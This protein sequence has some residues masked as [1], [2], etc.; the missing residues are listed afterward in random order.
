MSTAGSAAIANDFLLLF[1]DTSTAGNAAITNDFVVDFSGSS[2]PN[3]DGKLT[4]GSIS[5]TV[6]SSFYL[7]SDQLT[8]GA[9]NLSTTVA[10]V[11]SD[12]GATGTSCVASVNSLPSTGGSL[13]KAGTGMLTLSGTNT[14]TGGTKLSGGTLGIGNSQ[15]LGTGALTMADG[16]T[17]NSWQAGSASPTRSPS[18][19]A[20]IRRSTPVATR[21]RSRA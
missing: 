17:C 11:I 20:P 6:G 5:G 13:V 9:N 8:V 15:A 10:G 14:Y 12:C 1:Q 7:G 4:A 16:T 21:T 2:G 3:K 19:A 18:A